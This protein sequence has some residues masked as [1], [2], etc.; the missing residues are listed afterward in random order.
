M[1]QASSHDMLW[2]G[3]EFSALTVA[4]NPSALAT[5]LVS[6]KPEIS[7]WR[8]QPQEAPCFPATYL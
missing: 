6:T 8:F 5:E 3:T 1:R 2:I 4:T 7:D